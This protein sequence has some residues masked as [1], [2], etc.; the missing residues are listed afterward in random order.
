[1]MDPT[2]TKRALKLAQIRCKNR[3]EPI[4]LKWQSWPNG[5]PQADPTTG[6][7]LS[8]G[9][10]NDAVEQMCLTRAF[11]HFIAP[12]VGVSR[13]F[14]EVQTGDA[15]IDLL[16]PLVLVAAPGGTTLAAGQVVDLP[17]YNAANRTAAA[18][19]LAQATA[20]TM[21][22]EISTL[23][24]VQVIMYDSVADQQSDANGLV[25]T[26][27]KIG[28]QLAK[29]WESVFGNELLGQSILVRKAT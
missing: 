24:E 7:W 13:Q 4:A 27:A 5:Q 21:N 29:S 12:A 26:Q 15:I 19:S 2:R 23:Q 17:T 9:S 25:Y 22:F 8:N 14:A 11:V 20:T 10:S 16:I 18:A 3:G 1:M 28:D 6:A